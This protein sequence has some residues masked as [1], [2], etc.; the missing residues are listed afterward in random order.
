MRHVKLLTALVFTCFSIFTQAE[1]V[2][3]TSLD[4]PPYTGKGLKDN[5]ASV[6][7]AKAAFEAVGH[8]LVVEF[9][10]WKRAVNL[11]KDDPGYDG[12]FPEY[13]AEEL[14]QDFIL[15]AP[16][17]SG[18]LGFAELK[19]KPVSWN[20]I[21]ELVKFRIGVVSGYVNTASFDDMVAQ[22]KIK[23]SEASDDS[24]NLLKLAA[25][26]VDMAVVDK[27]V[28]TYLLSSDP[29]LK[30]V[31][32]KIQFNSHLLEDKSLYICFKK[33]PKGEKLAKEFNEGLGKIDIEGIMSSYLGQ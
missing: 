14:K 23:A 2:K 13:Y 4:W 19:D 7:V 9:Y 15:S 22:G 21:D 11:A 31:A 24:K 17:G 28:L 6:A 10:P 12:Y 20:S 27:N 29:Q 5:G 3:L 33:G 25:G 30:P 8:T 1:T 32:S 26:R 18:P 16:M